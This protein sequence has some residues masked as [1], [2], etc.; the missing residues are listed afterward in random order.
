MVSYHENG[1]PKIGT[2]L[3]ELGP[4]APGGEGRQTSPEWMTAALR[5]PI[6][7]LLRDNSSDIC[8]CVW[9]IAHLK[10]VGSHGVTGVKEHFI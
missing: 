6:F 5:F 10:T 2:W 7:L 1:E 9:L 4:N 8:R 3:N